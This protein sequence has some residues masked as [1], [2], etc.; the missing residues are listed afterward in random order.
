MNKLLSI[1]ITHS[2]IFGKP[3]TICGM[4]VK[5]MY[6]LCSTRSADVGGNLVQIMPSIILGSI[7]SKI[8]FVDLHSLILCR[9]QIFVHF[10]WCS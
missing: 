7:A 8:R 9:I 10:I 1:I 5:G 3:S 6:S 4:P 2:Q